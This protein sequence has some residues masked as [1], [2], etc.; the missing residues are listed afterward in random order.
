MDW[1]IKYILLPIAV[2]TLAAGV[3]VIAWLPFE[4]SKVSDE[5]DAWADKVE[6]CAESCDVYAPVIE[7]GRCYCDTTRPTPREATP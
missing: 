3:G 2:L 7:S 5:R 1:A 6:Q 4:I